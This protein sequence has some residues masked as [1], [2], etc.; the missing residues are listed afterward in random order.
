MPEQL[1]GGYTMSYAEKW[2]ANLTAGINDGVYTSKASSWL[3]GIDGSD[4]VSTAMTWATD[5]NAFVCT[6]V[7]PKGVSAVE[8]KE[9]DTTYYKS[10]IGTIELQ[11]AKAGYRLAAWL[12]II[13]TGEIG[14]GSSDKGKRDAA[15][16]PFVPPRGTDELSKA[17]L[18]R[19]AWGYGCSGH[20]H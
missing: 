14:L 9:L 20:S 7:M 17:K 6:V 2:A 10:A 1:I 5:S 8:G 11:I 4:T 18:A 19:A 16:K 15:P 13:A 12:N 3:T